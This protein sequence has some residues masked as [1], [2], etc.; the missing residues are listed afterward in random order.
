MHIRTTTEKIVCKNCGLP[1]IVKHGSYKG[2]Q[3]WFCRD[4]GKARWTIT[5]YSLN[6]D[7][8]ILS[9]RDYK[10]ESRTRHPVGDIG[11]AEASNFSSF[12]AIYHPNNINLAR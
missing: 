2:K 8:I 9:K 5:Q 10:Q 4:C 7:V 6:S 1:R 12:R 3:Q 11:D